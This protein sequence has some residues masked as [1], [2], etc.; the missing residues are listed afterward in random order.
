MKLLLTLSAALGLALAE[1][2]N[3]FDDTLYPCD[4]NEDCDDYSFYSSTSA[5]YKC[6]DIDFDVSISDFSLNGVNANQKG[7]VPE[8]YCDYY[9]SSYIEG[10]YATVEVTCMA[11]TVAS[12][13]GFLIFVAL[14]CLCCYCCCRRKRVNQ[15]NQV[16][17]QD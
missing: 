9:Q 16:N 13:I 3:P 11:S 5:I 2:F 4:I 15:P 10:I 8:Q 14:I 6:A 1:E 12:I 17:R 7:C